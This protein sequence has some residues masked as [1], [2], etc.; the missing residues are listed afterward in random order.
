NFGQAQTFDT[1][2][3]WHHG[4]EYTPGFFPNP[5]YPSLDYWDGS[6]WVGI[7]F[8][9]QYGTMHEEG[10]GS[11]YSDSDIYT[12]LPVTGSKVRYSF[13]N[14]GFNVNGTYNIH[15]WIYEF[16][17]FS[18]AAVPEPSAFLLGGV[19]LLFVAVARGCAVRRVRE[20]D[21]QWLVRCWLGIWPP[22]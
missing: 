1:V 20:R 8:Q 19:G 10:S 15:G 2:I 7:A 9:R 14:S 12:F 11:G 17:V 5:G 16:E 22:G 13:D 4:V 3:I 18:P 6:Q 21:R